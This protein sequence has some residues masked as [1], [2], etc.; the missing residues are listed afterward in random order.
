[1]KGGCVL[2]LLNLQSKD[3]H[4]ILAQILKTDSLESFLKYTCYLWV[5]ERIKAKRSKQVGAGCSSSIRDLK[6]LPCSYL[7]VGQ[8]EVLIFLSPLNL[9]PKT[10]A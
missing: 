2:F 1:M 3:V 6:S 4:L 10:Y 7:V 8:N 5:S 9:N